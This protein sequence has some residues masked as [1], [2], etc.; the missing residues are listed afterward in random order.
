MLTAATAV[1][2]TSCPGVEAIVE[3]IC[4]RDCEKNCID[5]DEVFGR[6]DFVN[7]LTT[8]NRFCF[9]VQTNFRSQ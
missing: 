7:T 3:V 6:G 4:K 1:E 9:V 2:G 5:L 8:I